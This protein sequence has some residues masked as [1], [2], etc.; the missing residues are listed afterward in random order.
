MAA[1]IT[2]TRL[3]ING[4]LVQGAGP[5]WTV[6]DPALGATLVD[7][8]EASAEQVDAAV[9]AADAA[10]DG[11]A[12]LTPKDRSVLLLKIAD[13]VEANGPEL[14]RLESRNCGKPYAAVLAD[15]IPGTVDVFRYFA[16]AC[17]CL[18]VTAADEYLPGHTS[19][20]RRDPVGV[21]RM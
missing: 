20:L 11:W 1:A 8:P 13:W 10:L 17:R 5:S 21:V 16:G 19:Y 7:V 14:A 2:S 9:R 3:L 12:A 4:A 6:L 18:S 15:E